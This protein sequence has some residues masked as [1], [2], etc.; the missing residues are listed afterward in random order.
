MTNYKLF[1]DTIFSVFVKEKKFSNLNKTKTLD[2][3]IFKKT[4]YD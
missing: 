2:L 1:N 3:R 4:R